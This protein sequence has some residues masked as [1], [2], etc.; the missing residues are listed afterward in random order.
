MFFFKSD[1]LRREKWFLPGMANIH[2]ERE[3]RKER[4]VYMPVKL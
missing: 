4:R 1:Q 2:C 3:V